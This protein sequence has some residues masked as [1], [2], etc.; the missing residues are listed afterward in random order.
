VFLQLGW[1][2]IF[3]ALFTERRQRAFEVLSKTRVVRAV[4]EDES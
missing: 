3:F 2:D 4:A 1:I